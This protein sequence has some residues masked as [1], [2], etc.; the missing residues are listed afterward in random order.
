ML[1]PDL[2][3]TYED[4]LRKLMMYPEEPEV[5]AVSEVSNESTSNIIVSN[6]SSSNIISN[7]SN[8]IEEI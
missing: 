5:H 8:I 3:K 4:Y 2:H 7:N 1:S 6:E